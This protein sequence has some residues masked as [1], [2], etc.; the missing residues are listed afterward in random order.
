MT[1]PQLSHMQS[2]LPHMT[3]A[4]LVSVMLALETELSHAQP[5]QR[6][7]SHAAAANTSSRRTRAAHVT[8]PLV[9]VGDAVVD[10]ARR[11]AAARIDLEGALARQPQ[12]AATPACR[13]QLLRHAKAWGALRAWLAAWCE[14][15]TLDADLR[16]EAVAARE[17]LFAPPAGLQFVTA[18]ALHA[19]GGGREH[20]A[21]IERE[22][23]A[24]V[25][26]RLGGA[27]ML[28]QVVAAHTA[29]GEA[30]HV[31][32]PA[33]DVAAA[34]SEGVRATRDAALAVLREY[35]VKVSALVTGDVPGSATLAA[36]LLS[37]LTRARRPTRAT[38]ATEAAPDAPQPRATGTTG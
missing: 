34:P 22:E 6:Q 29:L 8:T 32:R 11:V 1:K 12:H 17:A 13:A 25:F 21:T 38:R 31:T 35:V 20:L 2:P 28:A 33:N 24:A 14:N 26:E 19:W 36:R 37:P 5:S 9:P 7:T 27:P 16:A 3:S 15:D 18:A 23:L 4:T 10:C 30:L